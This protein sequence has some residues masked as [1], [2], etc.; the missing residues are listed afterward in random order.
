MNLDAWPCAVR[1]TAYPHAWPLREAFTISRGS[2]EYARV[3]VVELRDAAG[4]TGRGEAGGVLYHGETQDSMLE[5]IE[6]VR[7]EIEAGCD[8]HQL[9]ALLPEGGAR[10]AVDAALW[11]LEAR[12]TGTRAWKRAGFK[13]WHPVS[14]AA[15]LGMRSLSAYESGARSLNGLAWIKIKVGGGDP[16]EA[17]SA[18]RRGAAKARL[19]VDPNQAWSMKELKAYL[20]GL[21][22]MGVSLIEQPVP[23]GEDA[24]LA[25]W[26]SPIPLCADEAF[27]TVAD[28]QGISSRYQFVNIKLDKIGGLTAGLDLASRA[29]DAGLRLMVGC[30]LGGSISMA[31]GMVL[32]QCCEVCDLDGPLLQ[33]MDWDHGISYEK[34]VMSEPWPLLWG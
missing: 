24:D 11:D 32:G 1:M 4:N 30:M 15:T 26:H 22:R 14:S 9:L 23:A 17:V 5:Q 12:R 2:R 10:H 21:V 20:P 34:G 25:G 31:P 16:M 6:C 28:L 8:R 29:R 33:R 3:I 19:L 7:K 13:A 18:V 27:S